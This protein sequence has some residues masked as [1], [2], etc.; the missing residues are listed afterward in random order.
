LF[1]YL[2]AVHHLRRRLFRCLVI[3]GRTLT[4][5]ISLSKNGLIIV[6]G[7]TVY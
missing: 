1:A 2:T 4:I 6:E 5:Y 3:T 7:L